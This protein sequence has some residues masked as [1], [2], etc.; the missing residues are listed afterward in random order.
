MP[1]R[2]ETITFHTSKQMTD[3]LDGLCNGGFTWVFCKTADFWWLVMV[4]SVVAWLSLLQNFGSFARVPIMWH[5]DMFSGDSPSGKHERVVR[6]VCPSRAIFVTLLQHLILTSYRPQRSCGQGYVFTRVCDSVNR[7]GLRRTPPDQGEPPG[8]RRTPPDQGEPP[9]DQGE[10][11]LDQGEPTPPGTKENP[12]PLGPRRTPPDQAHTP[13]TKE[14]PQ[15]KENPPGKNTAAYGQWAAGTY[16]TGMHSSSH[17]RLL[18]KFSQTDTIGIMPIL[19]S[20]ALFTAWK[21]W[22]QN[23]T[24]TEDWTQDL[25]F[26]V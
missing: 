7:G 16:P 20:E 13:R 17:L 11:P 10:P 23:V 18:F 8:P 2:I 4:T 5:N 9:R 15:T 24:P 6:E 12:P 19:V 14:T 25:W 1:G 21:I 26:Q 3:R 22:W